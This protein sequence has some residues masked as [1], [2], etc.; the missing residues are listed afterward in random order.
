MVEG[1]SGQGRSMEE[2]AR[3]ME[4][5]GKEGKMVGGGEGGR[6]RKTNGKDWKSVMEDEKKKTR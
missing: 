6:K 5:R 2:G 4:K 3:V 1:N